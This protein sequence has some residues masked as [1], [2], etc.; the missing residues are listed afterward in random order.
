MNKEELLNYLTESI[1]D[2]VDERDYNEE[3][4]KNGK[5]RSYW[6]T[7]DKNPGSMMN[8]EIASLQVDKTPTIIVTDSLGK[9]IYRGNDAIKARQ[10]VENK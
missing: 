8:G 10:T 5:G 4:Y 6:E 2:L 1:A 7:K 3:T 9:A